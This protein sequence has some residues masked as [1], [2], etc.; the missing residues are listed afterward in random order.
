[1]K[2]WARDEKGD[3]MNKNVLNGGAKHILYMSMVRSTEML[4]TP[5]IV[6]QEE[7]GRPFRVY[8]DRSLIAGD[9]KGF[10]HD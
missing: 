9:A 5:K 3:L 2:R 7:I 10:D 8:G 1:V 6:M 4:R